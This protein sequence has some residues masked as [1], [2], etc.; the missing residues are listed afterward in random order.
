MTTVPQAAAAVPGE[1]CSYFG[2]GLVNSRHETGSVYLFINVWSAHIIAK[3]HFVL[4]SSRSQPGSRTAFCPPGDS[5]VVCADSATLCFS[6][7]ASMGWYDLLKIS[8]AKSKMLQ[9]LNCFECQHDA[10]SGKLHS[11]GL[12]F[13]PKVI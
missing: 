11:M 9:N 3:R 10:T 6:Y 12:C 2:T 7:L 1:R 5:L 13:M 8:N 4:F